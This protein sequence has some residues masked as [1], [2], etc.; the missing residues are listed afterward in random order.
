VD[1]ADEQFGFAAQ[2]RRLFRLLTR[3]ETDPLFDLRREP[4][5]LPRENQE[6]RLLADRIA[7]Y[8]HCQELNLPA[9]EHPHRLDANIDPTVVT[10]LRRLEPY[11]VGVGRGPNG[12]SATREPAFSDLRGVLSIGPTAAEFSPCRSRRPATGRGH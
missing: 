4:R 10:D 6:Q 2:R 9:R 3:D 1:Q 11:P 12:Y 5:C 8:E 7:I